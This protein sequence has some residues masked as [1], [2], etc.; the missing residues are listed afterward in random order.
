MD[1]ASS[2]ERWEDRGALA[3][4]SRWKSELEWPLH[5][6]RD[7]VR[8]RRASVGVNSGRA[9]LLAACFM[10]PETDLDTWSSFQ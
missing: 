6:G 9:G 8:V 7:F 2:R 1:C 5:G 3:S 4:S 10:H